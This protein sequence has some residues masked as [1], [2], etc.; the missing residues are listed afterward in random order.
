MKLYVDIQN[1]SYTKELIKEFENNEGSKSK[2]NDLDYTTG[3]K[4]ILIDKSGRGF[5][6]KTVSRSRDLWRYDT[7]RTY[8]RKNVKQIKELYLNLS[9]LKKKL[10][11]ENFN[12]D[13]QE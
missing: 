9:K 6:N 1:Q 7:F 2:L 4:A 5:Y 13:E 11:F 12:T 3:A 10:G 8:R